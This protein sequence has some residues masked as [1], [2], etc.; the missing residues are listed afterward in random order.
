M[1]DS[2]IGFEQTVPD[3]QAVHE[4]VE[5]E[6]EYSE[7]TMRSVSKARLIQIVGFAH[8]VQPEVANGGGNVTF[9]KSDLQAIV[10]SLADAEEP[11]G[12]GDE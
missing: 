5:G 6:R 8:G 9:N 11:E 1:T 3:H 4:M 12:D 7:D 2:E 10:R